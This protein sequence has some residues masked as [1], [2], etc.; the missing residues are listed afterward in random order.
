MQNKTLGCAI[1]AALAF[2]AGAR[3]Q[4]MIFENAAGP[5]WSPNGDELLCS[6]PAD[7]QGQEI[8]R[9]SD[10]GLAAELFLTE[11]D[12]GQQPMWL[13]DGK[14]FVY[15]RIRNSTN[16]FV[17]QS[18]DGGE[19]VVWDAP[20]WWADPGFYLSPDGTEVL[21]TLESPAEIWALSLDDGSTRYLRDGYGGVISPDGNWL[22]FTTVDYHLAVEPIG[23]GEL[24]EFELGAHPSWTPD[25]HFIIFSGIV[26]GFQVDLIARDRE[27]T[28][29]EQLTDDSQYELNGRVSPDGDRIV[30]ARGSSESGPFDLWVRVLDLKPSPT[31]KVTWGRLKN[32]YR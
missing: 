25:S 10:D 16:E 17:I 23:G 2:S 24:R 32:S 14:R 22:A 4:T 26:G 7:G 12:G 29:Y 6:R 20:A 27:G 19:P 3:S 1:L 5:W 15:P 30:Y 8:W 31:R 13:P 18:L 9:I 11:P 28:F 21:F